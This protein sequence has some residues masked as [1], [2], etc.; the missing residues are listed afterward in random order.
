MLRSLWSA[1]SAK[2]GGSVLSS[3]TKGGKNTR[4]KLAYSAVCTSSMLSRTS[5]TS[6]R[7][8]SAAAHARTCVCQL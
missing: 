4:R 2:E 7:R 1:L 6:A 8:C 3:L 5:V